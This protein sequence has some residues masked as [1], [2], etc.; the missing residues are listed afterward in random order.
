MKKRYSKAHGKKVTRGVLVKQRKKKEHV[1][2][3]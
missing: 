1:G 2:T 3:Y